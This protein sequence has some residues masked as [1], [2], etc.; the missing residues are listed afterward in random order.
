MLEKK[1]MERHN[2]KGLLKTSFGSPHNQ[3]LILKPGE[4][5][6]IKDVNEFMN[7]M[8]G[9]GWE[10]QLEGKPFGNLM[11]CGATSEKGIIEGFV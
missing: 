9:H 4:E 1:L 11:V 7:E 3:I 10:C 6:T 2:L 8:R 5:T